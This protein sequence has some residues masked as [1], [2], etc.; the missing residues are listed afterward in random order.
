MIEYN[1]AEML[2]DMKYKK[3][4]NGIFQITLSINDIDIEWKKY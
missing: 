2:L 3:G 1:I 4:D